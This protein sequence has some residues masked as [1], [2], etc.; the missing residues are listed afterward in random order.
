M[1]RKPSSAVGSSFLL[2]YRVDYLG[3]RC[4]GVRPLTEM[5]DACLV[6]V[7][8]SRRDGEELAKRYAGEKKVL[9]G[10]VRLG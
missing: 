3:P 5:G 6:G 4:W 10:R 9:D 8:R 1:P 2:G 7:V